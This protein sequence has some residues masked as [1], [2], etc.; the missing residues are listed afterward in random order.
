M[1][2]VFHLFIFSSQSDSQRIYGIHSRRSVPALP[3]SRENNLPQNSQKTQ[4][5]VGWRFSTADGRC[6][7]DIRDIRGRIKINLYGRKIS[8]V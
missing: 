4:K 7:C 1:F 2:Y 5:P 6:F 8:S 3:F